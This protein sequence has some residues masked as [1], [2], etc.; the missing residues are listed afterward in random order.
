MKYR[1][2][3]SKDLFEP[4]DFDEA[5]L[6]FACPRVLPEEVSFEVWGATIHT[7]VNDHW[8]DNLSRP[9]VSF[10]SQKENI[11][12]SGYGCV[13]IKEVVGGELSVTL[14]DPHKPAGD[15]FVHM[16]NGKD[17]SL[18]RRWQC[19]TVEAGAHNYEMYCVL[20]WPFGYCHFSILAQGSVFFEF[21]LDDC[22]PVEDYIKQPDVYGFRSQIG[23][24]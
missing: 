12:V 23:R 10:D 20:D 7:S 1:M 5:L 21:D 11:Y 19:E 22:I 18:I 24:G 15:D 8:P 6:S 3:I 13:S 14:Y 9:P 17:L 4:V 2:D 16:Q